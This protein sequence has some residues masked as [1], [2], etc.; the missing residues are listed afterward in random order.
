CGS[1]GAP[2]ALVVAVALLVGCHSSNTRGLKPG[3]QKPAAAAQRTRGQDLDLGAEK[4]SWPSVAEVRYRAFQQTSSA[5]TEAKTIG[6]DPS[7]G[8]QLKVMRASVT[9]VAA[10]P[11]NS[12]TSE[13]EYTLLGSGNEL[14]IAE[15][16]EILKDG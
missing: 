16:W 8:M 4:T 14:E 6:Y 7:K 15:E 10:G 3:M 9:P 5:D 2:V 11:G 13:M 1:T 12:I